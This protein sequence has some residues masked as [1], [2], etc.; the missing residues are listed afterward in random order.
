MSKAQTPQVVA[1]RGVTF[2]EKR[3]YYESVKD[4]IILKS[5][6]CRENFDDKLCYIGVTE[7]KN[8][9]LKKAK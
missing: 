5:S 8:E 1:I 7:G 9:N 2:S 3:Q 4:F 6:S